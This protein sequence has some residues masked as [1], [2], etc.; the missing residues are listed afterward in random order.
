MWL[1][2]TSSCHLQ[3]ENEGGGVQDNPAQTKS[4][5]PTSAE[6][7]GPSQ[8]LDATTF[9]T[10]KAPQ[11]SIHT[12]EKSPPL[13]LLKVPKPS[14]ART[15]RDKS[16]AHT[17]GHSKNSNHQK[18]EHYDVPLQEWKFANTPTPHPTHTHTPAPPTKQLQSPVNLHW[19]V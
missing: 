16:P 3:A 12:P 7:P 19:S 6:S 14:T 11:T 10:P 17:L 9:K 5:A 4:P 18:G 13:H 15:L 8:T 2:E 1:K